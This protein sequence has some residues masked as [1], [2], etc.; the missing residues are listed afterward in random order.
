MRFI[1]PPSRRS[2]HPAI[3]ISLIASALTLLT[4]GCSGSSGGGG[5]SGPY[6]V[7]GG[8]GT[9]APIANQFSG[10][11]GTTQSANSVKPPGFGNPPPPGPAYKP[12]SVRAPSFRP[13]SVNFRPPH[14]SFHIHG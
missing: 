7:G 8:S 4:A 11:T 2:S 12:P 14:V 13:P 3:I 10:D 9:A 1:R 5:A 6:S